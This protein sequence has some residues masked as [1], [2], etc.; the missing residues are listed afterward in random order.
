MRINERGAVYRHESQGNRGRRLI[1]LP[2]YDLGQVTKFLK[3]SVSLSV[4]GG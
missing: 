2:F 1:L 4:S 3:G